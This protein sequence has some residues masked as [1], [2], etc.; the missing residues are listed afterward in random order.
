MQ[1]A[2]AVPGPSFSSLQ[3]T[4]YLSQR[5]AFPAQCIQLTVIFFRPLSPGVKL[6]YVIWLLATDSIKLSCR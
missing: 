6:A 5:Q 2:H 4:A 3:D 1:N